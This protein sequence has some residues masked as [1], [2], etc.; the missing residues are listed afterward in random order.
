MSNNDQRLDW[1]SYFMHMARITALR[2][3]DPRTKVGA[4]LVSKEWHVLGTGYN[5]F[6]PGFP[7]WPELWTP[8]HKYDYVVHAEANCLLHSTAGLRSG[9]GLR[10]FTT[11]Y[12]CKECAKLVLT[13]GIE[14]LYYLDKYECPIA[15]RLLNH[16]KSSLKKIVKLEVR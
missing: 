3:K 14:E 1:E 2:S 16:S 8:E 11:L 5:G 6:P 9:S 15:D 13:A 10:L 4:V 7:D 12:P